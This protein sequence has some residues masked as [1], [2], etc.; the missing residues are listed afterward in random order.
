MQERE[1]EK[2]KET[3]RG[4]RQRRGMR[5]GGTHKEKKS[6]KDEWRDKTERK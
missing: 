6:A 5:E 2:Q 4:E 1:R 3:Q